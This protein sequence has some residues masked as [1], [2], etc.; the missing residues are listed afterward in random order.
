MLEDWA[1][2]TDAGTVQMSRIA[3]ANRGARNILVVLAVGCIVQGVRLAR[4]LITGVRRFTPLAPHA[5]PWRLTL[6]AL[7]AAVL[8]ALAWAA[9]QPY[10][11]VSSLFPRHVVWAAAFVTVA[12]LLALCSAAFPRRQPR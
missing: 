6:A 9:A 7:A 10:L 5:R 1:D 2:S 12:A 3:T 4:D 8:A 11:S